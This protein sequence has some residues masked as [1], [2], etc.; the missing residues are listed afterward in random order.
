MITA[1]NLPI[2]FTD[3]SDITS[4]VDILVRYPYHM[5]MVSGRRIVDAKSLLGVIALSQS[6]HLQLII[7]ESPSDI[8]KALLSDLQRFIS[9]NTGV[10]ASI[11]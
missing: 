10:S 7:H 5:D 3:A 4:F 9:E 1:L 2:A 6:D 11:A 8:D